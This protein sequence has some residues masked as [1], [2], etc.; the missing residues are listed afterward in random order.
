MPGGS[1]E[2]ERVRAEVVGS[3]PFGS[4]SGSLRRSHSVWLPRVFH[5][6]SRQHEA[7]GHVTLSVAPVDSAPLPLARPGQFNMLYSAGI[8]EIPVSLSAIAAHAWDHTIRSVGAT[9]QALVEL[10]RG[11]EL[12]VRGPF[13]GSWPIESCADKDLLVIAGGLG[14]APLKPVLDAAACGQI[15]FRKAT[16]L[17]GFRDP[18]SILFQGSFAVWGS[19]MRVLRTV[20]TTQSERAAGT[21]SLQE[22]EDPQ[23]ASNINVPYDWNE[24]VGFVHSLIRKVDLD[25]ERTVAMICG[26]EIMMRMA[27]SSLS[28]C[29][30]PLSQIFVSLERSMKCAVGHC[31]H[32][33]LGESLLCLEGPIYAAERALAWLKVEEL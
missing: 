30:V 31:G 5:V 4:P 6:V 13:G 32:C 27:C 25:A 3:S 12:G 21:V 24:S 29:G 28:D 10:G 19:R 16:L 23:N 18:D 33:Q 17:C 2:W 26:P 14:L 22:D 20:D 7:R 9:S 11:S 8:G 1:G 15:P